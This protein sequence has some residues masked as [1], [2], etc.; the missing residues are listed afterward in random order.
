MKT[1]DADKEILLKEMRK[2]LMGRGVGA[3]IPLLVASLV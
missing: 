1:A 3:S 2:N